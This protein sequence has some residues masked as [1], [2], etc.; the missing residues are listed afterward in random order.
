MRA[1]FLILSLIFLNACNKPK[2]PLLK[3]STT[4]DGQL[5]IDG[6]NLGTLKAGDENIFKVPLDS[7]EFAIVLKTEDGFDRIYKL[8]EMEGEHKL[9]HLDLKAVREKR[10]ASEKE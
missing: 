9:L 7:G 1:I 2:K 6:E 4:L 5:F 3:I 10:V 8:L